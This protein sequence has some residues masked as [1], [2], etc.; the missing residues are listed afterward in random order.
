MG[1]VE[2][3]GWGFLSAARPIQAI[4][5]A[6][7]VPESLRGPLWVHQDSDPPA[8]PHPVSL[9]KNSLTFSVGLKSKTPHTLQLR[10]G[11][12][13]LWSNKVN[14]A[15]LELFT[16]RGRRPHRAGNKD[17]LHP[18]VW[19]PGIYTMHNLSYA[20]H[21]PATAV[22]TSRRLNQGN[23]TQGLLVRD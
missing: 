21:T 20:H 2:R 14:S 16:Q 23:I 18:F 17:H 7:R 4:V 15:N 22:Q 9:S 5:K 12:L 6:Q 19:F 3:A 13:G 11:G 1:E 10:R 8:H